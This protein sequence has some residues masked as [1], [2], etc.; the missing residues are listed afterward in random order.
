MWLDV[1]IVTVLSTSPPERTRRARQDGAAAR[2]EEMVKRRRYGPVVTPVVIET[3]GRPGDIAR[4]VL[5]RFA[6]DRGQGISADV[7]EAWQSPSALV[8][9]ESAAIELRTCG[10]TPSDWPGARYVW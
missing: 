2:Q 9:A 5:G 10:F 3:L 4:S 8:Q 6:A 7:S 1:A